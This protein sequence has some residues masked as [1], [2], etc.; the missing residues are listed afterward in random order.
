MRDSFFVVAT[1]AILFKITVKHKDS[2]IYLSYI[3]KNA[4]LSFN[5]EKDIQESVRKVES[6]CKAP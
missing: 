5:I 1:F 4:L 2:K 3:K 6:N